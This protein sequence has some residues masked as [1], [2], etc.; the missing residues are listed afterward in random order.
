MPGVRCAV[1][2]LARGYQQGSM[3]WR[4]MLHMMILLSGMLGFSMPLEA[5]TERLFRIAHCVGGPNASIKGFDG[6]A[7]RHD[8]FVYLRSTTA[9]Q[10]EGPAET[11]WTGYAFTPTWNGATHAVTVHE[12]PAGSGAGDAGIGAVWSVAIT[13]QPDRWVPRNQQP[14]HMR[15]RWTTETMRAHVNAGMAQLISDDGAVL[16]EQFTVQGRSAGTVNT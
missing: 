10:D 2:V 16:P 15:I 13:L 6:I 9:V 14:R 3:R 5:A 8:L 12:A 7:Q 4:R 11:E 1:V